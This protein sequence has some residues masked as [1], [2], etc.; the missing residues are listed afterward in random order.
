M[1]TFIPLIVS[2]FT[3]VGGLLAWL[4]QRRV[5]LSQ[6]DML[7]KASLYESLLVAITELGSFGNGAPILIESQKAWLYASDDVLRAVNVYLT[8]IAIEAKSESGTTP[9]QRETR[10]T[11]E[12]SIRLAIRR[13]LFSGTRLDDRWISEEWHPVAS[14]KEAILEYLGR[15]RGPAR[16]H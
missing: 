1:S 8:T 4:L 2:V 11:L 14:S 6:A 3:V 15:G 5:E 9:E 13:D 12:G 10:R 7:R 16:D